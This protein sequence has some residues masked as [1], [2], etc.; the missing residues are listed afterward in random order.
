MENLALKTYFDSPER[1]SFEEIERL[2]KQVVNLSCIQEILEAFPH[3]AL[4]LNEHRQ[5]VAFNS[6]AINYFFGANGS[7]ILGKRLGEAL[8]FIHSK[9]MEAGCGTSLFC[10][11]CG[12]AQSI[13]KTNEKNESS[14]S[15]CRITVNNFDVENSLD[16]RVHTSKIFIN[17]IS[18]T[19]F[20]V[21]DIQS[22]KRK[23]V[24]ERVFFHDVLNTA[25]A[26]KGIA[27]ILP[28][29]KTSDEF[30]EFIRMLQFSS[31]QLIDEIHA[32]RDLTYAEN[33]LLKINPT[34]VSVNEILS[35]VHSLYKNHEISNGMIL[36][37]KYLN[38]D[39]K[40]RTD[41]S[42][43]VRSLGNLL[44]NALEAISTNQKVR[45]YSELKNDEVEFCVWNEGIITQTV[46]LQI[47][48]RSFSTKSNFGRGIGTYSVK[49][50]VEKYLGGKV[51]FISDPENQTVFKV[52]LPKY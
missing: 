12:A 46:Q 10:R 34:E 49:L 27:E 41:S 14:V 32:Q 2:K 7:G 19:L 43:L 4:L 50:F 45:V 42:L 11:E 16:F 18:F 35:R 8:N 26:I 1:V 28:Q 5:I 22:E 23:L 21:E 40:I 29:L 6:K 9:E 13:K 51:T 37:V 30:D 52:C 47:F 25:S 15:E 48:Q 31:E 24:L 20:A 33:G 3:I 36:E 17:G 39:F 44:K 38:D